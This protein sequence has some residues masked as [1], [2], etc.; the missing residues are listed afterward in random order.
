MQG[1]GAEMLRLACCMGTE[2]GILICAPVQDAVLIKAPIDRI[3]R[4]VAAMRAYMEEAS[5]IVLDG[6][7]LQ[8]EAKIVHY[9]DRY[10]DPRGEMMFAKVMSLL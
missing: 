1:N 10:T 7:R 5:A 8:T 9:P 6:F 2:N 3:D 4:D